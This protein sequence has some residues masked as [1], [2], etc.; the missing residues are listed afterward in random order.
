MIDQDRNLLGVTETRFG[1]TLL[2]CL[3]AAVGFVVLMR[4]GGTSDPTV[5]IAPDDGVSQELTQLE[6]TP[7]K[8]EPQPQ[9]LPIEP[10]EVRSARIPERPK[11]AHGDESRVPSIFP[12]LPAST[13]DEP[14][15]ES[16][17]R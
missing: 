7:E 10:Q 5:D 13:T 12:V 6:P 3:L 4:L 11:K 1:L 15:F 16:Q 8:V 14:S 17:I 9:V 2:I